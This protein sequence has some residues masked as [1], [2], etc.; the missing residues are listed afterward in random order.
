MSKFLTDL[1]NS[2]F[3][4]GPTS[5]LLTATNASFLTLQVVL[6]ALLIATYS[7][8]FLILS[9]LSAGLWWMINWFVSELRVQSERERDGKQTRVKGGDDREQER[10][11]ENEI[12]AETETETE[13][14]EVGSQRLAVDTAGGGSSRLSEPEGILRKRA[15]AGDASGEMSTDSEWEKV[16]EDSDKGR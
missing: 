5:T 9:F 8:H 13:V 6:G 12:D 1:F 3:I 2:I 7:I 4:P 10:K 11:P 16:D 15:S 14:E